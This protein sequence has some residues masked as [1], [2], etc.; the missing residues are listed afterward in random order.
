[1]DRLRQG[2]NVDCTK[3]IMAAIGECGIANAINNQITQGDTRTVDFHL[4]RV[5]NGEFDSC[6]LPD[7]RDQAVKD[8]ED[9]IAKNI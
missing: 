5:K 4:Q 6:A 7:Q 1:M 3:C 8:G 9:F 2:Q